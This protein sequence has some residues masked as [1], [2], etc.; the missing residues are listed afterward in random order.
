MRRSVVNEILR[1][2]NVQ[3]DPRFQQLLAEFDRQ[4]ADARA[5]QAAHTVERVEIAD[6]LRDFYLRPLDHRPK[7]RLLEL[8]LRY[9]PDLGEAQV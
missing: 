2:E 4:T 8:A 1:D 6:A 7:A 3:R 9:N 5:L